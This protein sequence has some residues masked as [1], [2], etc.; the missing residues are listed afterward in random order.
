MSRYT[1]QIGF[2][3]AAIWIGVIFVIVSAGA[4]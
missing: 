1:A 4:R 2:A 3:L